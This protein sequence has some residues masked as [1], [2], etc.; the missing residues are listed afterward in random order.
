MLAV[1]GPQDGILELRLDRPQRLNAL[2]LALTREL[3]AAVRRAQ[4][5]D[6]SRVVLLTAEGRGFC[7]GKDRDDPATAEFVE[8]LQDLARAL[9][10]C[11]KPVV[12][13]VQGWAVGAGLEL[14]LNC[15]IVVAA[16][17]AR[18]MLPEV[19]IGL[20]GTGGVVALLPRAVGMAKAKGAL[21]LGQ[22]FSAR[23]AEQWGLVWSVVEDEEALRDG[24]LAV[25]RR[26]AQ[27]CD[28]AV[29]AA[30][31]ASL[32]EETVGELADVLR[33]EAAIQARLTGG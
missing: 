28:A 5:D 27:K 1:T 20:F 19:T 21:M 4:G 2:T 11:P 17:S 30:I 22:E 12:A 33:R 32:H 10:E 24:A 25:A 29:L 16:A 23:Q 15:D 31:K 18:F 8:A 9:M 6:A 26:L 7:A 3:A 13:A 14:L